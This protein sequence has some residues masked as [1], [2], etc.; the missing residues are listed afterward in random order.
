MNKEPAAEK[1]DLEQ[2][3]KARRPQKS[4][5]ASKTPFRHISERRYY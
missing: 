5:Y 3:I 4:R 2:K 1:L